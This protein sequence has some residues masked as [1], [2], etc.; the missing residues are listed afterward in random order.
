M[1]L[2]LVY[3]AMIVVGSL[4]LWLPWA[5]GGDVGLGDAA[6]TATSAIT[7]TGLTVVTT[8]D[9]FTVFGQVVI[10]LLIQL[11]GLGIMTFA[12]LLLSAIG[13]P[14]SLPQ[15][16]VLRA[17]LNQTSIRNLALLAR[18][19]L[20][21]A[22]ACE[23]VGAAVLATVFVPEAGWAHGLWQAVF[24]AV[25]GFNNAGFSLFPDS[26][27]GF[28]GDPRIGLTLLVL[29]VIGGLGFVV[30]SELIEFRRWSLL[31]LH[32]K[33]MLAGTVSLALLGWIGF[34]VLEWSNPDTLGPLSLWS[35]V[36][37]SL[38]Q[39][40]T[41]RTAGFNSID[42]AAIN[43]ATALLLMGLMFIG[44]GSASTAGGIKV[45]TFI[46][47]VLATIAFF[48][49]SRNLR[50]FGR[51]IGIE[52]VLK[53]LA[54]FTISLSLIFVSTFALSLDSGSP[55][56]HVAFEAVSAFGT[57]GLSMGA[58]PELDA[59]GRIVLCVTMFL[60]RIG[61]LTLGFFLASRTSALIRYPEGRI[62]IG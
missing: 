17:D 60:G 20:Y 49:Q 55:F 29:F 27:M 19:V 38:F 23:I 6:F 53:V 42:M 37:T 12:A 26:L 62:Y 11:G 57:V 54:V 40:L 15:Q 13:V 45:T 46:V 4:V 52:T 41:P 2:A 28:A 39:G 56:L 1:L 18:R 3:L 21:V 34:G 22:L 7:V 10:A 14:I 36:Q 33:L 24:H 51:S 58:T 48:R 43:D 9:D 44:G 59:F 35:K 5:H 47:A 32:A 50:A 61:P 25:S 16:M 30:M 8:G 31:S